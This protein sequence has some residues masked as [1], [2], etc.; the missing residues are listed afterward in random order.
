[1][2]FEEKSLVPFWGKAVW[3]MGVWGIAV[4]PNFILPI[5]IATKMFK[6]NKMASKMFKKNKMAAPRTNFL[7]SLFFPIPK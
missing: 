6:K 5:F 2:W 7:R 1:M 3:G 4:V